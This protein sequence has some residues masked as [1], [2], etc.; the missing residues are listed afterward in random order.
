MILESDRHLP[1][2]VALVAGSPV[3]GS[4]WRHPK[5][6][7]IWAVLNEVISRP[8]IVPTKLVSGKVTLVSR[9]LWPDLVAVGTSLED[10][11][12]VALTRKGRALLKLVEERGEITSTEAKETLGGPAGKAVLELERRLLIESEQFHTSK[13][14]H[15]KKL[16][17]W[18]NWSRNARLPSKV[19]SASLA[20]AKFERILSGLNRKYGG[21]GKLP[22]E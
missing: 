22:W 14:F 2:I 15:A 10:W 6:R 3:T 7:A 13:G 18:R 9:V 20:K 4:W 17:S 1:S 21:D 16:Q 19:P 8:D 5:G 11:Q 12:T